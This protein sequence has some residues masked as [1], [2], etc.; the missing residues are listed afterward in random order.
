MHSP[1][2]GSPALPPHR[3]DLLYVGNFAYQPNQDAA[4][5]LVSE[6]FPRITATIPDATLAVVGPNPPDWLAREAAREPRLHVPGF[7]PELM[8]WIDA[9]KVVVCPLRVGGGVKVKVLEA[10]ACGKVLVTTPVGGQGLGHLPIDAFRS[11]SDTAS[12]A[13]ACSEFLSSPVLRAEQQQR[14]QAAA[15]RLPT[16]D[17]AADD[18]AALWEKAM[19]S[20]P[21]TAE[22]V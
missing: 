15:R 22:T 17:S 18:L 10:L 1:A 6:I 19:V 11:C 7:V 3:P 4:H 2:S 13:A 16:W 5:W 20:H 9:A 12:V 21:R 14:A 8:P